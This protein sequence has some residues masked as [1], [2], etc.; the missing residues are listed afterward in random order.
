MH[1]KWSFPSQ[2][3]EREAKATANPAR[4][5]A[6]VNRWY[7]VSAMGL[8]LNCN[9]V[10]AN[11]PAHDLEARQ[12][13]RQ[14]QPHL[15]AMDNAAGSVPITNGNVERHG[16]RTEREI[17]NEQWNERQRKRDPLVECALAIVPLLIFY[18]TLVTAPMALY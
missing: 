1:S 9:E 18:L 2:R 17:E 16:H 15:R 13:D 11:P 8:D 12:D 3:L 7:A 10:N 5:W 6:C 4:G 14:H